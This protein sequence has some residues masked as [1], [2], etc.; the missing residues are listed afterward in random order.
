MKLSYYCNQT[1][2]DFEQ[3][4]T[5]FHCGTCKKT[6]IDFTRFSAKEIEVY[7]QQ[8]EDVCGIYKSE[9]VVEHL[10][11]PLD[12]KGFW[13][14]TIGASLVAF[15]SFLK[16]VSAQTITH[17]TVMTEAKNDSTLAN[18]YEKQVESELGE[19]TSENPSKKTLRNSRKFRRRK[20]FI[21]SRFPFLHYQRNYLMGFVCPS[22]K[23]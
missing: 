9:H 20:L 7:H 8:H 1:I 5:G 13:V 15:F 21:S 18:Y 3:T 14:K 19:K 11:S 6:L 17:D 22:N 16:P 4:S 12:F 23:W 2:D 10:I